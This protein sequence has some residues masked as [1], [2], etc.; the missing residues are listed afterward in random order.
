MIDIWSSSRGR[1]QPDPRG[2]LRGEIIFS[3]NTLTVATLL[4]GSF[5]R[6]K[7]LLR[8]PADG[9]GDDDEFAIDTGD[10]RI[11]FSFF[12]EQAGQFRVDHTEK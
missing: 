11:Y 8:T 10:Y 12:W 9:L 3:A 6:N 4:D 2:L 5:E 1:P 7:V